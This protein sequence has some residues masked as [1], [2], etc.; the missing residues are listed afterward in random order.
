MQRVGTRSDAH[1]MCDAAVVSKLSLK[2]DN[3]VSED[4][5]AALHDP[6]DRSVKF[7][8]DLSVLAREVKE[9]NQ[10]LGHQ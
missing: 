1:G 5:L 6:R 4:I 7:F 2:L 9:R 8:S 10:L 3:F